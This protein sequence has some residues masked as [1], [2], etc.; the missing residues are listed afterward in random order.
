GFRKHC[1]C[2]T[3]RTVPCLVLDPFAGSGTVLAMA[4]RLGRRSIGIE[5]NPDYVT[6]ARRRSTVEVPDVVRREE[7][8][9]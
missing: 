2:R 3:A 9:A 7:A 6:L 1:A 4:R 8:S 5:L